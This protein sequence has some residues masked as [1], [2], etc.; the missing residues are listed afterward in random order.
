GDV[1][2]RDRAGLVLLHLA[3]ELARDLHRAHL[4]AEGTTERAFDEA[5]DLALEAPEHTHDAPS[6]AGPCYASPA[7]GPRDRW[8]ISPAASTLGARA[9]A[10]PAN[11]PNRAV[12]GAP[13]PW[14]RL[15]SPRL[16]IVA[17]TTIAAQ[18]ITRTVSTISE[19][20]LINQ[21]ATTAASPQTGA[22]AS[23]PVLISG[24][25]TWWRLAPIDPL[26]ERSGHVPGTWARY[27]TW[28]LIGAASASHTHPVTPSAA[29]RHGVPARAASAG[30]APA[31]PISPSA[32]AAAASGHASGRR[33]SRNTGTRAPARI[34]TAAPACCWNRAATHTMAVSAANPRRGSASV[35]P[36]AVSPAAAGASGDGCKSLEHSQAVS[37][38]AA[39]A[40]SARPTQ[41][42]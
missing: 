23:T 24:S 18:P 6:R 5:G 37:A 16:R 31:R 39:R 27:K 21:G 34:T 40:A 33:P 29:R 35:S 3:C 26:Q 2:V 28:P 4:G 38:A 8:S 10:A 32:G 19:R 14:P 22:P 1:R 25:S 12:G 9:T 15:R 11:A 13:S 41:I 17:L 36:A 7:L 20:R 30:Q 42:C